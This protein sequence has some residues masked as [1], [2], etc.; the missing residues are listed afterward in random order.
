MCGL[1]EARR[2]RIVVESLTEL[3]NCDFENA[4]ADKGFGPDRVEEFLFGDELARTPEEVGED[5]VGFGSEL[6]CLWASAQAL[7]GQ[8]QVKGIEDYSFFTHHFNYQTSPK[9]Y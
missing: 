8:V 1:N 9:F 7:V 3:T 2:L 6:N 5:C 4:L